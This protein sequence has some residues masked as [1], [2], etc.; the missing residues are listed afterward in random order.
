[1]QLRVE[2]LQQR[3]EELQESYGSAH[4]RLHMRCTRT[5]GH[6]DIVVDC[7]S[8]GGQVIT[9]KEGTQDALKGRDGQLAT[10]HH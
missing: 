9:S 10:Q 6:H 7:A 3:E 4:V 1:M 5:Q 8:T 2:T